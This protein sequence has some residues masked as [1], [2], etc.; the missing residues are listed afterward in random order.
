VQAPEVTRVL[1]GPR[2]GS[3]A[4]DPE[5]KVKSS[6]SRHPNFVEEEKIHH[7]VERELFASPVALA[8]AGGQLTPLSWETLATVVFGFEKTSSVEANA[9][10]AFARMIAPIRAAQPVMG[11]I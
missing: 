11:M 10:A 7:F 9:E 1:V 5:M 6:R 3:A 8:L 4:D 2:L